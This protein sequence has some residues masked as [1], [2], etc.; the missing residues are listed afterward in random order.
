MS[1]MYLSLNEKFLIIDYLD[2]CRI[3]AALLTLLKLKPEP[4][5]SAD[6]AAIQALL[7]MFN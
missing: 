3:L 4:T 1:K 5:F 7:L 6:A 2:M